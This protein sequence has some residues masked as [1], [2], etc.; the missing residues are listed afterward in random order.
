MLSSLLQFVRSRFGDRTDD[1]AGFWDRIPGRQYT[2]RYAE[3]G[4]VSR[5]E[6]EEA[7]ADVAEQADDLVNHHD[8]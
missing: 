6:Q 3:S 5:Q 4:G 1:G 7:I 2:G 8:P